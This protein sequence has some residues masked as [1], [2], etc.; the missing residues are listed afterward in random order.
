MGDWV[1]EDLEAVNVTISSLHFDLRLFCKTTDDMKTLCRALARTQKWRIG[2]LI[3]PKEMEAVG[4]EAL[5]KVAGRGE[6]GF[7]WVDVLA[8][9]A[10]EDHQVC[11]LWRATGDDGCWKN[12]DTYSIIAKKKEGDAGLQKLLALKETDPGLELLQTQRGAWEKCCRI[13]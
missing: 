10:A 13:L 5:S 3:L 1:E 9:E 11:A 2:Q 4:W 7:V 8:L 12:D 6:V